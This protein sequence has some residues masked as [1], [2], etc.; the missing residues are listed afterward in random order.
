MRLQKQL[1][2]LLVVIPILA[3]VALA[4]VKADDELG[5]YRLLAHITDI[6]GN[7]G[8][9]F[10]I[11]WVDSEAG[12]YYL[13][14]RGV[15][16]TATT[17][18]VPPAVDVIDTRHDKFLFRVELPAAANGVVAIHKP[19]DD[20]EED[21]PGEVWVGDAQSKVDVIDLRT[22]M[23]V[24][25][26]ATNGSARADEL[27]YDPKDHILLVANDRDNPPFLTFIS[28]NPGH[29]VLGHIVYPQAVFN[30]P[31]PP[32]TNHGL[33]QPVWNPKTA[34]F[35][36]AVPATSTNTKGEI[37]EINPRTRTVTRIFPTT[38]NPAGLALLP[39]Q[40]LITSCGD[41]LSVATGHVLTTVPG[42]AGDE[43]WFNPGDDRV[44]FGL[45]PVSVVDASTLQVVTTISIP[46]VVPPPFPPAFAT[47]SV[48]AD[49]ENNHIFIPDFK[50]GV[51]VY[52]DQAVEKED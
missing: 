52:T 29:A 44:Y 12:R 22:R 51:F 34:R 27:A 13:A 1:A 10:D 9:G 25:R 20:D 41:V 30:D 31:N 39:H 24:D 4:S 6:P 19:N 18:A 40:R 8:G 26:V 47:H 2:F 42:V 37:D 35:Y 48:A 36:Q 46:V 5:P 7:L 17:P 14:D 38:C 15:A 23:I 11:S 28:T 21:G 32:A 49:S 16:A 50:A 43:I 45:N 3:V 33:E